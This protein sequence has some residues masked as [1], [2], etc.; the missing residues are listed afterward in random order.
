[1][2]ILV[3]NE[4]N[5]RT[6]RQ[7]VIDG[8]GRFDFALT[9]ILVAL[10]LSVL[11]TIM[12]ALIAVF[13]GIT[14]HTSFSLDN[15]HYLLYFF[16]QAF[17]YSMFGVLFGFLFKKTGIAIALYF[18]YI[19]FIKNIVFYYF[20]FHKS[21]AGNYFPVESSD[22]LIHF[23]VLQNLS[24]QVFTP[25]NQTVLIA[26]TLVYITVFCFVIMKKFTSEDL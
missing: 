4:F 3:C 23:P 6:H 5:F 8:I 26:L 11:A 7:N 16:L 9:K 10:K 25:A 17:T 15:A 19:F 20:Q 13:I 22:D 14:G 1:M 24:R 21:N 18:V 12:T 2:L